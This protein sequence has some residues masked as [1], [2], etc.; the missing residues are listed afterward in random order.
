MEFGWKNELIRLRSF[1]KDYATSL[2]PQ[3]L[4]G[5]AF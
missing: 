5:A 1:E 3:T 4:V 2:V